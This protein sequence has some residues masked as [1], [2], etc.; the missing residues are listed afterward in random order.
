MPPFILISLIV[1]ALLVV[2]LL[3][4]AALSI[5]KNDLG[6]EIED[7][8]PQGYRVGTGMSIGLGLGVALGLVFDNLALGIAI[9]AGFGIAIG[10][11]LEQKNK[12]KIRPMTEQEKKV[13]RWGVIVGIVMLLIGVAV[14]T[15]LLFLKVR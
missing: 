9:G 10:T 2:G 11:A 7:K 8:Y 6:P 13:Q 15:A 1:F 3:V 14:F 12:D 4:F 5:R